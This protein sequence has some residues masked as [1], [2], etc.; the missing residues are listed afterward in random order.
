MR[1]YVVWTPLYIFFLHRVNKNKWQVQTK[2]IPAYSDCSKHS[3]NNNVF[4]KESG[5]TLI[6]IIIK[7]ETLHISK[8][9]PWSVNPEVFLLHFLRSKLWHFQKQ[10]CT[11]NNWSNRV[12]LFSTMTRLSDFESE[13]LFFKAYSQLLHEFSD[14]FET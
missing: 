10:F 12:S 11:C 3:I 9:L 4:K 13:I 8:W 1:S 7:R 14:N 5:I 2:C 6:I